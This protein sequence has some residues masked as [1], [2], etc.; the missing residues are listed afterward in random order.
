VLTTAQAKSALITVADV[1][2]YEVDPDTPTGDDLTVDDFP[3]GCAALEAADKADNSLAT[4]FLEADFRKTADGPFAG[5]TISLYPTAADAA[6]EQAA[7]LNAFRACPSY[8]GTGEA[9]GVRVKLQI[10]TI[11]QYGPGAVSFRVTIAGDAFDGIAAVLGNVVVTAN[12]FDT[13]GHP[14]PDLNVLLTKA[15]AKLTAAAK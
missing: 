4:G 9:K 7:Y 8:V 14:A 15:L 3:P 10:N 13:P 5:E 6:R 2:G 11:Q 12:G 1:P